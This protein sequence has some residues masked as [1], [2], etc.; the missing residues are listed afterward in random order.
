M[1]KAKGY[2]RPMWQTVLM[3]LVVG[4][5]IYAGIYY[6]VMGKSGYGTQ[7]GAENPSLVVDLL[8][9]NKSGQSGVAVLEEIDGQTV[10]SL[11]MTGNPASTVSQ[12]AHLHVGGCPATGAVKYPLTNV[13]DGVSET[14]LDVTLDQ[15]TTELPLAINVYKSA[16][17]PSVYTACGELSV[18]VE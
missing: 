3:Y 5:L 14:T 8:E 16:S 12:P 18:E 10:V 6:F 13:V 1:A 4:G 15:I 2:G 17:Q 11:S 9:E 7:I